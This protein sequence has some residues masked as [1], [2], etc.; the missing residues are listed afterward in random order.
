MHGVRGFDGVLAIFWNSISY[1]LLFAFLVTFINKGHQLIDSNV[2]TIIALF[3]FLTYP[4][5]ILPWAIS[6]LLRV[7]VSI[8]RI[9]KFF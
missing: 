2:F 4:L 3:N 7:R 1:F 6:S 8:N 5:G 9:N